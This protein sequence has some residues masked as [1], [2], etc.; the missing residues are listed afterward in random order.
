MGFNDNME[1]LKNSFPDLWQRM[2]E[3]EEELDQGLVRPIGNKNGISNLKVSQQFIHGKENP[4]QEAK[5]FIGQFQNVAEHSDILFYGL[6]M[7][8]QIKAFLEQY[9]NMPFSIYEPVPEVFYQFLCHTD[10][11]ELPFRLLK[12]IYIESKP[13]DLEMYSTNIVGCIRNSILI[14]ELPSYQRI[15]P[16][17]R[18]AFFTR[19]S[20]LIEERRHAVG[21]NAAFQKRWTINSL[22]NFIRVLSTPDIVLE[23]KGCFKN[24]P[25]IL[26]ASGPALEEEIATLRIIKEKGM[27]YI[28]SV[29]TAVNTLVQHGVYPDAACTYDPS[30][31]NHIVFKGFQE[32]D[33]KSIPLFFGSTVGY[34][35][36]EIYPGPQ[37]HMLISQDA[38]SVFYLQPE[39]GKALD[40]ISDGATIAV[41]TLQLLYKLGFNPIILVG[42]NLAFRDGMQYA[43]GSTFFPLE[44]SKYDLEK[45]L[46]VRDV[47]GNEVPASYSFN[48]MRRQI[49][50]YLEQY[51]DLEVINTTQ[52]GAHIEG[53]RFQSLTELIGDTLQERVVEDNWLECRQLSYD[54]DYLMGQHRIMIDAYAELTRLLEKC[55][56]DLDTINQTAATQDVRLIGQSYDQF[57]LSME[58]LRGNRFF[59][60]FIE[61]MNRVEMQFLM[62]AVPEIS[63]E[64]NPFAKAQMMEREF[65][66][67]L[68]SCEKDI[69]VLGSMFE[70]MDAA[71]K[72]YYT[73]YIIRKKATRIKILLI[74][75]DGIITDGAIYFS[76]SGDGLKKC[77]VK[78]RTG[79]LRLHKQGIQ[80]LL[81][82]PED[83]PVLANAARKLGINSIYSGKKEQLLA[84]ITEQYQPEELACIWSDI[85][86]LNLL[87]KVGLSFTVPE[88]SPDL[89]DEVDCVLKAGGGG[90][91]I[92]EISDLLTGV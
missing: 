34:E 73:A 24:K 91:A 39:G 55:R 50:S 25:A 27:A 44:A 28:F 60:T 8:Y 26:V 72:N 74:D 3:I 10:L 19:F 20:S 13:E 63:R 29:G 5:T 61:P 9:P 16:E 45:A 79:I 2:V 86:D 47:Y 70:E 1:V 64:Q 36:L 67:F 65:A 75:G 6:G 33:I 59:I 69:H 22:K 76:S 23:K 40:L 14:I 77:N 12:N 62:L 48:G 41:I 85:S 82:N 11:N 78:D 84:T 4:R 18:A 35:T 58:K 87:N 21:T 7:G 92:I 66:S 38:L 83:D 15:F 49:E 17:K 81:I 43:A 46:L 54:M 88:A 30:K 42:L 37:M 32:N 53:S 56:I 51:R 89:K 90:G 57:N 68:Q 71:I 80:C 31:E 52:Y